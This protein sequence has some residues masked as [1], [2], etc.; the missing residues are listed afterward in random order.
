M[1]GPHATSAEVK[2][3][4]AERLRMVAEVREGEEKEKKER[5]EQHAA[6]RGVRRGEAEGDTVY[7]SA[8]NADNEE[9]KE[10][11]GLK[12]KILHLN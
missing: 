11:E 6:H 7:L 10:S 3:E 8:L 9:E 12:K 4:F 5:R 2:E 1:Q